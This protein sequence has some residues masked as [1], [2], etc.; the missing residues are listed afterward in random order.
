[1][2][3]TARRVGAA[4]A[5]ANA[6]GRKQDATQINQISL[7]LDE[8]DSQLKFIPTPMTGCCMVQLAKHFGFGIVALLCLFALYIDISR[9]WQGGLAGLLFI[10]IPLYMLPTIIAGYRIHPNT[11]AVAVLKF[12]LGW[13]GLGWGAALAWS[14]AKS[15]RL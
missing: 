11:A 12:L 13:T 5:R 6:I 1:M 3:G 15:H 14:F 8:K 10:N 2:G 9:S 7:T 4:A